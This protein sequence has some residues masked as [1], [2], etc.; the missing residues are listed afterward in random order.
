MNMVEALSVCWA[1]AKV[2]GGLINWGM[3]AK[4]AAMI[5]ILRYQAPAASSLVGRCSTYSATGP[6]RPDILSDFMLAMTVAVRPTRF[7]T[8]DIHYRCESPV[9]LIK[10][11]K[12]S[13]Q[14]TTTPTGT[15]NTTPTCRWSI[16]TARPA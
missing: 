11:P 5:M 13:K 6:S 7:W 3:A 16:Q 12:P 4:T 8:L 1:K 15:T 9:K 10:I 2:I 14:T